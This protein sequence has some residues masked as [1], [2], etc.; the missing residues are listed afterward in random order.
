MFT[1]MYNMFK[2]KRRWRDFSQV[3]CS[4]RLQGGDPVQPDRQGQGVEA[5]LEPRHPKT[6]E[7]GRIQ[8]ENQ[9]HPNYSVLGESDKVCHN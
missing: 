6:G 9:L 4:S 1:N 5:P 7:A 2:S 8:H 3:P